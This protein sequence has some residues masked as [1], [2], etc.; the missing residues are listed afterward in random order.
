MWRVVLL[1][2]VFGGVFTLGVDRLLEAD[3][4]SVD[5]SAPAPLEIPETA[6][7]PIADPGA[8]RG[9]VSQVLPT[10]GVS[11][12][13]VDYGVYPLRGAGR[14]PEATLPL[15]SFTC[16]AD[17]PCGT[18]FRTLGQ[19]AT[20]QGLGLVGHG[21]EDRPG[22]ALHR[23]LIDKGRPALA[24]RA[25]PPGPRVTVLLTGV[26]QDA[27]LVEPLLGLDV[28]VTFAV[29]A[30]VQDA[31]GVARRLVTAGREIIAH[32]PMEPRRPMA[33]DQQRYLSTSMSIET[34]EQATAAYLE[35]VPGA[36]GADNHRG[37]RLTTSRVH[38]QGVLSV[39]AARGVFFFDGRTSD[40]SVATAT[41]RASGVRVAARTHRLSGDAV[42]IDTQ[43]KGV[44]V[45]LA[46][47]GHAVVVAEA[48]TTVLGV[49]PRWLRALRS[50][51][52]S[53]LRLSEI[54]L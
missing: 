50:R 53:L 38:M 1:A 48:S 29:H 51:Q 32:L 30:G 21:R 2:A 34:I 22:R 46:L 45:A 28:D 40:A 8:A 26:G 10:L 36:V 43:L 49:L 24:L 14:G 7:T 54:V 17:R 9:L 15:V 37:G 39:L 6:V 41:A 19:L 31:P 18:I 20:A 33:G 4:G 27:A 35:R 13:A 16:P 23:A 5:A 25:Y 52:V 3:S 12:A 11:S 47:E 42:A 44:E